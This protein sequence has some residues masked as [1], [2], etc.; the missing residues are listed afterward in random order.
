MQALELALVSRGLLLV[1]LCGG[2]AGAIAGFTRGLCVDGRVAAQ[3]RKDN[4]LKGATICSS[5]AALGGVYLTHCEGIFESSI[6]T[7]MGTGAIASILATAT[8]LWVALVG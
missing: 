3:Q 2:V 5:A 4:L 7:A 6:C 8:T 1:L